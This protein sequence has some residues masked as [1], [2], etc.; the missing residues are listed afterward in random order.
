[1]SATGVNRAWAYL[2][3]VVEPPCPPLA[4]LVDRCGPEEAAA[5]VRAGR[6]LSEQ[7]LALTEARRELECAT[8]D[9]DL[10]ERRGGRLIT[11]DDDEVAERCAAVVGTRAATAY[12]EHVAADLTAGLV[13]R[14][15]AVVSG[16]AIVL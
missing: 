14:D 13:Q 8:V 12:G 2:S 1:M 6:G 7:L 5:R 15:V 3:R 10:L 11:R 9:L 4:D 16:G